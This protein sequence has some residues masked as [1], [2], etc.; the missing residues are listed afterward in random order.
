[1]R[2][3]RSELSSP[4]SSEKMMAKAAASEADLVFLDL[5]DSVA[6]SAKAGARELVVHALRELNWGRK[7]RAIRIN[8]VDSPFVHDDLVE[9]VRGAGDA[10]DVII[11]P[12]VRSARDVWF[13]ETM[14]DKLESP[15]RRAA[16]GLEVLI[17]EVEGVERVGEIARSSSRLEALIFGPGDLAGSQGV[18][19]AAIGGSVADYPG[20]IW[21][22]SRSRVVIAARSAG[23]VA[24]DGPFADFRDLDGYR[25]EAMWSVSLGFSGKWAIHPGQLSVA[26][27]VFAPASEDVELA[28]RLLEAYG[29]GAA[30]GLG[31]VAVDGMM[32]DA[33]TARIMQNIVQ[34]SD[35][36]TSMSSEGG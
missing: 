12:K 33:A 2:L 25:R 1:M 18:P 19:M 26:N 10:L 23:I 32:V 20:D 31:S 16:I 3:R 11:V 15:D 5:E 21:H 17:E 22:Y 7:I 4:G 24:I 13:V 30:E 28:R 35:L 34:R 6:P 14:L 9:V 29:R 8:P 36:V 27:E